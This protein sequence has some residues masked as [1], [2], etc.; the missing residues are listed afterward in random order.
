MAKATRQGTIDRIPA[1]KQWA[2]SYVE[3]KLNQKSRRIGWLDEMLPVDANSLHSFGYRSIQSLTASRGF[4]SILADFGIIASADVAAAT[5]AAMHALSSFSQ[6]SIADVT[7]E[8]C[9]T[10]SLAAS[11]GFVTGVDAPLDIADTLFLSR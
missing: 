9:V 10:I 2:L 5:A 1:R 7:A 6:L 8:G 4:P 3:V 11:T